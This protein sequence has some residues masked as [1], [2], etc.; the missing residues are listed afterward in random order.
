LASLLWKEARATMGLKNMENVQRKL[1]HNKLKVVNLKALDIDGKPS[2][3]VT[4][5][6][7]FQG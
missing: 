7:Q 4:I 6:R 2:E 3:L 5:K 1:N